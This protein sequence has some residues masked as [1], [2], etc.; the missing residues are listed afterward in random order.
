V[1][2]YTRGTHAALTRYSHGTRARQRRRRPCGRCVTTVSQPRGDRGYKLAVASERRMQGM[3]TL[4]AAFLL[5]FAA[6]F[7]CAQWR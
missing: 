3:A 5:H 2:E 1:L 6:N 7:T 4:S